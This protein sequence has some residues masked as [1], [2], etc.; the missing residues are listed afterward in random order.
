VRYGIRT[1]LYTL[2]PPHRGYG[3][4]IF[5]HQVETRFARRSLHSSV[6]LGHKHVRLRRADTRSHWGGEP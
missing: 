1:T 3:V 2:R 5:A 4:L 6:L